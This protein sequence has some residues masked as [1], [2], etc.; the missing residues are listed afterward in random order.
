MPLV[1]PLLPDDP[2]RVGTYTLM[3]RVGGGGMGTV[4]LARTGS[5]R[6]AAV[7]TV[8]TELKDRPGFRD[9]LLLE[10][11][12]VRLLGSSHTAAFLAVDAEASLPWLA[13]GY[14]IGPSL[15][16]AV[17]VAGPL[18]VA[19]VVMLGAAVADTL[20]TLHRAGLVHRDLKPANLLISAQGPKLIDFGLAR[21]LG[22]PPLTAA[23]EPA[24]T[25][26]YM[27][28]ELVRGEE[29]GPPGDVFALAAVLVFASSGHGPYDGGP[30]RDAL[31]LLR[32]GAPP[33]LTGVPDTLRE[34]IRSALS[35]DPR[36]RPTLDE[37]AA[38]WGP[39][40][41]AR[42]SESLPG[43]VLADMS[44]RVDELASLGGTPL[45]ED[46][47]PL[48]PSY[49]SRRVLLA[50]AAAVAAGGASALWLT[51]RSPGFGGGSG[52]PGP[53]PSPSGGLPG[54]SPRQQ[55][56]VPVSAVYGPP[57]ATEE[58]V[59]LP[60][61]TVRGLSPTSGGMLWEVP[62][63]RL[64]VAASGRRLAALAFDEELTPAAGYLDPLSG[65]LMP[66]AAGPHE[67]G[68]LSLYSEVLNADADTL[69]IRA[70]YEAD[71]DRA[72]PWLLAYDL[73]A[74]RLRWR[75]RVAWGYTDRTEALYFRAVVANGR[76]IGSDATRVFAVDVRDGRFLWVT[77]LRSDAE[78]AAPGASGGVYPPVVSEHHVFDVSQV[79]TA[80]DLLTGAPTWTL[81][82]ERDQTLL[83]SPVCVQGTVHIASHA[84]TAFEES[85]G[86]KLWTYE[87]GP[88]F[89]RIAVP[90]PFRGEL[91]AAVSGGGQAVVAVDLAQR[92]A[93]W[94]LSAQAAG[95][96][97][98]PSD[99]THRDDRLYLQA[100]QRLTAVRIDTRR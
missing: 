42:F 5:G 75:T 4:Y 92:R 89:Q 93:S 67:L 94:T 82:P 52:A 48:R 65:R 8:R 9:R 80:V 1:L 24:G 72:E 29:H 61:E 23:G 31:R 63:T 74:H 70:Y 26:S 30:G 13:T 69:Y 44:R 64:R 11:E 60:G 77:R 15:S 50:G 68:A 79:I 51:G 10:A 97:D 45:R 39:Y 46:S 41:A 87:P 36:D 14:L 19:A 12:A 95:M 34:V 86:R 25:P 96:P 38:H 3:G 100:Y 18:P 88:S 78:A 54:G 73:A 47:P 32:D 85:T 62:S 76:L 6:L 2:A 57:V 59:L 33:E 66:D 17:A 35:P 99:L 43:E 16:E 40:E 37:L 7:K 22:G 28:P 56:S 91:Y 58:L 98:G 49:P 90:G 81:K 55:W 83:T 53:V 27:S 71:K 84:F 21:A 20:T